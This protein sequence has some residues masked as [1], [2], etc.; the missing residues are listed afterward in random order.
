MKLFIVLPI[1]LLRRRLSKILIFLS[2][3]FTFSALGQDKDS[4]KINYNFIDSYPQNAN[5]FINNDET[6]MTPFFFEWKDS[7]FPKTLK[8]TLDGYLDHSETIE[9]NQLLNKK[10]ML[11]PKG[12]RQPP[13]II[14]EDKLPYFKEPRKLLPIA[15]FTLL[16][17]ASGIS[18][19]YFKSLASDNRREY[20]IF[21]DQSA[22][23]KEK[24]YDAIG[25]VS[26]VIFQLSF[27][28]LMYFLFID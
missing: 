16:T 8:V 5:I 27:A 17:A 25:S 12:K 23:D 9:S 11:I 3:V 19:F 18:A 14:K 21:G 6:G 10:V 28:T 4:A 24:K 2:F 7:T 20:E 13:Y 15:G 1:K 22:K 26:M